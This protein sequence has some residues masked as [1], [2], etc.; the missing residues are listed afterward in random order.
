LSFLNVI[1][2][3]RDYDFEAYTGH[4][5]PGR[6]DAI[7]AKER[8]NELDFLSLLSP[9]ALGRL[10]QSA[11]KAEA[12]A[13]RHF[14]RVV[15]LFT[16]MYISNYCENTCAYCSFA[17]QRKIVRR[18]LS[19]DEIR[20]EARRIG[21]SGIRHVL[22]LT[23]ESRS[24]AS[25]SY[26]AESL[27]II[28]GHFSSVGIETYPLKEE[29]YGLLI[30]QG[31]DGLTL[32]QETYDE[33]AYHGFHKGGP[34]DDF[35]FRLEAIDRACRQGMR[36]VSVGAL[37]GLANTCRDA[38]FTGLHAH[39]LLRTF[40]RTEVSVSFPRIRPLAGEF[41][42]PSPVSDALFVQIIAAMRIFLPSAGITI[43]TRESRQLRNALLPLGV[44]K[45]SAGVSTAVGGHSAKPSTTQF[46]IADRRSASELKADL[47]DLGF[48]PVMQDWNSHFLS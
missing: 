14:G 48:Q 43:S 37:L 8:I 2:Q 26:L 36:T 32:F 10:E 22:V 35:Q 28:K 9:G 30:Q 47:A 41:V 46:E 1:A 24:M 23:G 39:Y 18:H 33:S 17:R 4:V 44:T 40:P 5:S 31:I 27:R 25:L 6:I 38:F 16:P 11:Q 34:K 42:P 21:K 19:F 29:E 15:S 12:I 13:K 45:M 3:Y 7:L 20:D